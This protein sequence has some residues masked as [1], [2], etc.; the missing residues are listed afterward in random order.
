MWT[1]GNCALAGHWINKTDV[2][3][4]P[5]LLLYSSVDENT[6]KLLASGA[7]KRKLN[8]YE[9]TRSHP[10]IGTVLIIRFQYIHVRNSSFNDGHFSLFALARLYYADA[11]GPVAFVSFRCTMGGGAFRA[12][13]TIYILPLTRQ[14]QIYR[15]SLLEKIEI[16]PSS[17][18]YL[19]IRSISFLVSNESVWCLLCMISFFSQSGWFCVI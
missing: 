13:G 3:E 5:V 2:S 6:R 12:S 9:L 7:H 1:L 16:L 18:Q 11:S 19:Q 10:T 15:K 14:Q 17:K 8:V 4:P